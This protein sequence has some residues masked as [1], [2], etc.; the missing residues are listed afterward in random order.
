MTSAQ[1]WQVNRI[2][3]LLDKEIGDFEEVKRFDIDDRG[4]YLYIDAEWGFK[5]DD[6]KLLIMCRDKMSLRIGKRG[7]VKYMITNV[8]NGGITY[9]KFT[10]VWMAT[11]EYRESERKYGEKLSKMA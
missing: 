9:K 2:K 7:S 8:R 5:N 4:S 1:E 10:S 6:G 11:Y 3:A